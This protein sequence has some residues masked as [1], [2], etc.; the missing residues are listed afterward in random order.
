MKLKE[1]DQD[2]DIV[3]I[4]EHSDISAT[5]KIRIVRYMDSKD[6]DKTFQ[7]FAGH[8]GYTSSQPTTSIPVY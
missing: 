1:L 4:S 8:D 7:A 5:S 6:L 3:D 2:Q